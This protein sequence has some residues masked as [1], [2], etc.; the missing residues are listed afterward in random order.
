[1]VM[2][3]SPLQKHDSGRFS[4][5]TK[6]LH[7]P[8]SKNLHQVT[9]VDECL[10]ELRYFDKFIAAVV[11]SRISQIMKY[12]ASF[13]NSTNLGLATPLIPAKIDES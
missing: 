11:P 1:M 4:R 2:C 10:L 9:G 13:F 5:T 8:V 7:G 3:T 12:V 6:P